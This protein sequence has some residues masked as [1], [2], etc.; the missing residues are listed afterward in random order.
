MKLL[1]YDT[2]TLIFQNL[3]PTIKETPVSYSKAQYRIL[4]RIIIQKKISEEFFI[5]ML[6]KLYGLS[7]WKKLNYEQMYELIYILSHWDYKKGNSW[8]MK[9]PLV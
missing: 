2:R 9:S 1:N 4:Y 3:R 6:S 8:A 5:F 7:D